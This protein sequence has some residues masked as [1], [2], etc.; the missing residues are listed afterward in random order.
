MLLI[1]FFASFT[2]S[3]VSAEITN[4]ALTTGTT[5]TELALQAGVSGVT[6]GAM[7]YSSALSARIIPED[8]SVPLEMHYS[9]DIAS[10]DQ[11]HPISAI[12]STLFAAKSMS[13][14]PNNSSTLTST[15]IEDKTKVAGQIHRILKEFDY[16]SHPIS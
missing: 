13:L 2:P 5:A 15:D 11:E 1:F 4:E 10:A 14:M 9:V 3:I 8:P 16:T 6:G 12:V 7:I